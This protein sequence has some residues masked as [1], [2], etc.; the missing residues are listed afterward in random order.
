MKF[1]EGDVKSDDIKRALYII[2]LVEAW[3]GCV[4]N[5]KGVG[6]LHI[7]EN[8]RLMVFGHFVLSIVFSC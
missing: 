4:G 3:A 7:K 5:F 6:S 2:W 8:L 1:R